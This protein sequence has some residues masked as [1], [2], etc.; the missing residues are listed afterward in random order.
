MLFE[1]PL[2]FITARV[3]AL[4]DP[5]TVV[6]EATMAFWLAQMSPVIA[7]LF[8]VSRVVNEKSAFLKTDGGAKVT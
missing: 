7:S 4:I 1:V 2:A 5:D 8:L 6:P 3:P